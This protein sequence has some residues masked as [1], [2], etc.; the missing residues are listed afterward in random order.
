MKWVVYNLIYI[1]DYLLL[2]LM[3][4]YTALSL[5][6]KGH[7]RSITQIVLL[8]ASFKCLGLNLA[9]HITIG[10]ISK[11]NSM[12][13]FHKVL[14][15]QMIAFLKKG[16]FVLAKSNRILQNQSN[17]FYVVLGDHFQAKQMILGN[18]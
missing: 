4:T 11:I 6:T 14:N 1:H 12:K 18:G 8:S 2:W 16:Q 10:Y 13:G 7:A 9:L 5:Q 17:L 3:E 15:L